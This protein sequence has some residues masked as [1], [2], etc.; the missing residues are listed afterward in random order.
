ML[1]KIH[2]NFLQG[3]VHLVQGNGLFIASLM[4]EMLVTITKTRKADEEVRDR[5]AVAATVTP[6]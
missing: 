4:I 1:F 6:V 3:T 2:V 5:V